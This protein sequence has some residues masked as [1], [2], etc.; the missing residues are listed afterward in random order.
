MDKL[1]KK[2][3][4]SRSANLVLK[5]TK[6]LGFARVLAQKRHID[7]ATDIWLHNEFL[8]ILHEPIRVFPRHLS[9]SWSRKSPHLPIH[10]ASKVLAASMT[11][12]RWRLPSLKQ[13]SWWICQPKHHALWMGKSLKIPFVMVGFPAKWA[14]EW[15]LLNYGHTKELTHSHIAL[16]CIT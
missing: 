1:E 15:S 5:S 8:Q 13:G 3:L 11:M 9:Q 7:L 10:K 4:L 2:K 16:W 14:I 6:Q 12:K